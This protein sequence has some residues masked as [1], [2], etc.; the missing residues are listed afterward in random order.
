MLQKRQVLNKFIIKN[1]K[2]IAYR[3]IDGQAIIIDLKENTFNILND[4][5]TRIW[6]LVDGRTK[7]KEI[8][9]KIYKEFEVSRDRLEKDCLVLVNQMMDRGLITLSPHFKGGD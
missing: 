1:Y 6:E 8:V 3:I 4:V 9:D 7:V 5:A 2:T